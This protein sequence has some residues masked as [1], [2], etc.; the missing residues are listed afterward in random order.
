M[1]GFDGESRARP[2]LEIAPQTSTWGLAGWAVLAWRQL[3]NIAVS[4]CLAIGTT[5]KI[6]RFVGLEVKIFAPV[7]RTFENLQ[8]KVCSNEPE[9]EF[10]S[11]EEVQKNG[12][13]W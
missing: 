4:Y 1:L 9:D 11:E 10:T 13:S 5:R 12:N 2:P 7:Q 3:A 8:W 6:K